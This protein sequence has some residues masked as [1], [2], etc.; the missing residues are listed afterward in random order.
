[1]EDPT[2]PVEAMEEED[3]R[4]VEEVVDASVSQHNE[5]EME[6][7]DDDSLDDDS[8]EESINLFVDIGAMGIDLD[9]EACNDL[10]ADEM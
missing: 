7:E 3:E 6:D 4:E 8:D 9:N 1:M 5:E 2:I 10:L